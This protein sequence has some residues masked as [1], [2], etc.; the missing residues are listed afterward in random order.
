MS[1]DH[2]A[3]ECPQCSIARVNAFNLMTSLEMAGIGQ[4]SMLHI[5][6][7]IMAVI[8]LSSKTFGGE[9]ELNKLFDSLIK[10]EYDRMI[11]YRNEIEGKLPGDDTPLDPE[12]DF[13]KWMKSHGG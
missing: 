7:C 1:N 8:K 2:K 3:C 12:F 10:R 6:A 11:T 13:Q 9:K 4:V 5:T